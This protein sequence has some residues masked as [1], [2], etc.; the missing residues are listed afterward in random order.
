VHVDYKTL[1]RTPKAVVPFYR[2]V[3]AHNAVTPGAREAATDLF[4][5][6]SGGALSGLAYGPAPLLVPGTEGW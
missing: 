3:I 5:P 4:G 1:K 2:D 6:E